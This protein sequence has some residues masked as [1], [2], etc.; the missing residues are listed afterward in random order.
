MSKQ[1]KEHPIV[2]LLTASI[3][4]ELEMPSQ[5]DDWDAA[6]LCCPLKLRIGLDGAVS[7]HRLVL[8]SYHMQK[9]F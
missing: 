4:W 7:A 3:T 5:T 9:R 1:N 2:M 8:G 6:L